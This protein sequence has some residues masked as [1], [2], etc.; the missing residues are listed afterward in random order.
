MR[1]LMNSR[2]PISGLDSPSRA[3]RAI[4]APWAV[5]SSSPAVAAVRL[6]AVSPVARSSRPARSANASIPMA[7]SMSWAMRSCSRFDAAALPAQ[8]FAVAQ[9][10]ARVPRGLGS[11]Q[12]A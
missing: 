7:S 10:G 11:G 12:G 1:A 8:P 5:S 6:R 9:M 3:S 4:W 2:V